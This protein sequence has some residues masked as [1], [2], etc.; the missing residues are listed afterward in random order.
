MSA[1][2][3]ASLIQELHVSVVLKLKEG[4]SSRLDASPPAASSSE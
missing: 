2:M 1:S 4:V 3:P